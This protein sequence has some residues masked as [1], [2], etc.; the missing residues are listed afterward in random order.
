[1]TLFTDNP[2]EVLMQNP[3][4]EAPERPRPPQP[5]DPCYGCGNWSVSCVWPCWK[6]Y[7]VQAKAEKEGH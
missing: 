4:R 5:G 1:M 2:L 3:E 7:T 6:R